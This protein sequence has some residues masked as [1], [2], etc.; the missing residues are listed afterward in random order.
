MEKAKC[1][2]LMEQSMLDVGTMVNKMVME[3]FT[4]VVKSNFKD[5]GKMEKKSKKEA[6]ILQPPLSAS[7]WHSQFNKGLSFLKVDSH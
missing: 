2:M 6:N 4:K 1:I 5:N 3:K 7:D